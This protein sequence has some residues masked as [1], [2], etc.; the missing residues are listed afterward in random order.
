V[1]RK[2]FVKNKYSKQMLCSRSCSGEYRKK[3][4]CL[5]FNDR[6]RPWVFC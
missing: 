1:C 5:R 6:G 3:W 4:K 2:I